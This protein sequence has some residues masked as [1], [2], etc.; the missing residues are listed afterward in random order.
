MATICTG[1]RGRKNATDKRPGWRSTKNQVSAGG[2]IYRRRGDTIEVALTGHKRDGNWIWTLA[3]GLVEA[4]EDPETTALREVREETGLQGRILEK[5]GESTYW[6]F[7]RTDN[8]RIHKT[9]HF[10]LLECVGGSTEDH[11]WEA[12]EVRW[13]PAQEAR[14][15]LTYEGERDILATAEA[16]LKA[17]A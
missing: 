2:V 7:S 6:F 17:R 5:L 4:T 11:D 3:K 16:T 15:A 9:V 8:A 1:T 14:A 12:D 13:F 10:Y